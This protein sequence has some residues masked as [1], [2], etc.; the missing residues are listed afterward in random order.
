MLASFEVLIADALRR[1]CV[2]NLVE[3]S[4]HIA[5][6]DPLKHDTC[7]HKEAALRNLNSALLPVASPEEQAW[8]TRLSVDGDE[9]QVVV[10]ASK[11]CADL[12]LHKVTGCRG[13]Q[14]AALLH[15]AAESVLG[16]AHADGCHF[17]G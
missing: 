15:A 7:L 17:S 6:C 11:C 12:I 3:A 4:E 9:V 14:V 13:Q 1:I 2:D 10:E 16:Q 5:A 8:V